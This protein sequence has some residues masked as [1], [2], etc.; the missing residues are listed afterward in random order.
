MMTIPADND[1]NK[2]AFSKD[3]L[4]CEYVFS[5]QRSAFDIQHSAFSI[6]YSAAA[7][8]L[9]TISLLVFPFKFVKLWNI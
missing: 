8:C 5:I 9:D 6:S 2:S 3:A 7:E 1:D 4:K